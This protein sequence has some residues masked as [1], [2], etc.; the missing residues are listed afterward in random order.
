MMASQGLTAKV[1]NM[2]PTIDNV[3]RLFGSKGSAIADKSG[4]V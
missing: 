1:D 4:L 3:H 2:T